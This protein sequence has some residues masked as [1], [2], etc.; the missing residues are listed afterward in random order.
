[1]TSETSEPAGRTDALGVE[2]QARWG[3]SRV[4]SRK[5]KSPTLLTLLALP[6]GAQQTAGSGAFQTMW[7][8]HQTP[9]QNPES[10]M[11]PGQDA[12]M[13]GGA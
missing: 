9:P 11:V 13:Q 3:A 6:S 5:R 10:N 2:V 1:M 4:P 7:E 8:S 12:E